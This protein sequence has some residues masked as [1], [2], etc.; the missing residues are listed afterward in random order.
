MQKSVN[1]FHRQ[2]DKL[3]NSEYKDSDLETA[4]RRLKANLLHNESVRSKLYAVLNTIEMGESLDYDNRAFEMIDSITREDIDNFSKKVFAG[5]PVY[6]IVASQD[7][8]DYN[9]DFL[10]SLAE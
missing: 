8:L 1:G 9:K 10:N 6:S 3:L 2:I 5:K 4:K 7:T